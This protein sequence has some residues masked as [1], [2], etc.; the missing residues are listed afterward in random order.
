MAEA[1]LAVVG[2]DVPAELIRAAGLLPYRLSADAGPIDETDFPGQSPRSKAL[3]T[4]LANDG[5]RFA[6]VAIAHGCVEDAQLFSVLRELARL[7]RGEWRAVAYVDALHGAGAE[8]TRYNRARLDQFKVWLEALT[9]R[10]INRQAL[11]AEIGA[12]N[13]QRACLRRVLALRAEPEPRLSGVQALELLR[14]VS[15]LPIEAADQRIAETEAAAAPIAGRRVLVTGGAHETSAVYAAIEAAGCVIVGEDHDWGEPWASQDVDETLEPFEALVA[16]WRSPVPSLP[17]A[18]STARAEALAALASARRVEVVLHIRFPGDESAPWDVRDSR[19]ALD[20]IGVPLLTLK[21][22]PRPT[23]EQV[24]R[25]GEQ[26]STFFADPSSAQAKSSVRPVAAGG[27]PAPKKPA[28]DSTGRRSRKALASTSDFGTWQREWFADVQRRAANGPFAVVNADAP[29]EI[30]R[31]MDIPY[32]VNQ[33]WASIVAAKQRGRD[34]AGLL[35][36]ADYP[37]DVENYSAQGLAA[38]LDPDTA[39]A[40]WGGLPRPDILAVVPGSDAG[41]KIFEAWSRETGAAL[42]VFERSIDSR[43][44]LPIAWWSDLPERWAQ[45]L[46]T[47]RL[48]L[49]TAQLDASIP[50]LEALTGRKFDPDRFVEVMRLVNEQEDYYRRT[51]DLIAATRPAPAGIA[52]TMPATMVPQW[53]RGTV[54]GRDAA[55]R[56][57]EEVAQRAANGEAACPGER[58]R[59]MWVGRGLWSDMGF[60][61]RWEESHGAVF[62]WSMYL[63]LAADGYLRDFEGPADAMRALAARFVTMG[64][65]LRMP[66]WAGAWHVKEAQLHGVNGAVAIDDAD[67]FVLE[68]LERAG[69][70]VL[71]LAMS[72]MSTDAAVLEAQVAT[73]IEGL[74]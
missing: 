66:T 72:N 10:S 9:G 41:S 33:W 69:V 53:H 6:G 2:V 51:R 23:G 47:E 71:R 32:V 40:P 62:V 55:K 24:A 15:R 31:A 39:N 3:L 45:T 17:T 42:F 8:T 36:A 61:Q 5:G 11:A 28:P 60:Y 70:P 38:A 12:A 26:L 46:E 25:L 21:L 35:K 18:S 68:A 54:W 43:W 27:A 56:F 63:G 73:F 59:L 74:A 50:R 48:D 30:L 29:Q 57:Y 1:V 16:R 58:V 20:A 37:A 34:Y 64:D 49:M 19:K 4:Q 65:E 52:D 67:P 13:A 44:D 14:A 7:G 22:D